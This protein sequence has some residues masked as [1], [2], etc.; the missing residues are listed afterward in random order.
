[1]CISHIIVIEVTVVK[2]S[3]DHAKC[4]GDTCLNLAIS[5]ASDVPTTIGASVFFRQWRQPRS[6]YQYHAQ[7]LESACFTT[8]H[9][10]ALP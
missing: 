3:N 10:Y 7:W 8:A 2:P 4:I 1:M 5:K 9:A 6:P